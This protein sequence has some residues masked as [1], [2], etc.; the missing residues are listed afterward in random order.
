[1]KIVLHSFPIY[2]AV[3]FYFDSVDNWHR[4]PKK[5]LI[6]R[7]IILYDLLNEFY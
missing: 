7:N 6:V 4:T 2:D 3:F 1:M 5:E